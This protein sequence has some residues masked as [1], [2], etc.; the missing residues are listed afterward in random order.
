MEAFPKKAISKMVVAI[1]VVIVI[2]IATGATYLMLQQPSPAPSPSPTPTPIPT[3]TPTVKPSPTPTP[4]LTSTPSPSPTPKPTL[5][6]T[7]QPSPMP[8]PTP[9]PTPAP[10]PT[11]TPVATPTPTPTGKLM[12]ASLYDFTELLNRYKL[13][14]ITI[15]V[16]NSTTGET[17]TYSLKYN[18][19]VGELSG[20][21]VKI[22]DAA[23]SGEDKETIARFWVT[24]DFL[25]ALQM[26]IDN[27]IMPGPLANMVWGQILSVLSSWLVAGSGY[28][29]A[30]QFIVFE[31]TVEAAR[32]G[33]LVD[34]FYPIQITISGITYAGYY[35]KATNVNDVESKA[36][37]VE[38]KAAEILPELYYLVYWRVVEK[39]GDEFLIEI[40]E[41]VPAA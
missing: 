18:W 41:L 16:F 4:T 10:T 31:S 40:S 27:Q 38:G 22:L 14:K 32:H 7:P 15:T 26:R 19:T 11:P 29:Y 20:Q 25:Q 34:E 39:D 35:G 21:Q 36:Q 17:K 3:P 9:T 13:G 2:A 12:Q 8:S 5:T 6:P 1:I 33:W 24:P 28:D 37:T 23:Y 30:F